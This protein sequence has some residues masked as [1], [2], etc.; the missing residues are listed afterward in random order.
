MLIGPLKALMLPLVMAPSY[1]RQPPGPHP[2]SLKTPRA[3]PP[4][5]H[6][7]RVSLLKV[8]VEGAEL[9]VLQG[10]RDEDWPKI[11]QVT[12]EV[13]APRGADEALLEKAKRGTVG[14]A[15]K[16]ALPPF[17]CAAIP[18]TATSTKCLRPATWRLP[19]PLPPKP[20]PPRDRRPPQGADP[21]DAAR[22]RLRQR[23]VRAVRREDAAGHLA[24][25]RDARPARVMMCRSGAGRPVVL[26]CG[27][28][29]RTFLGSGPLHFI[30][31][32]GCLVC[33]LMA[34]K[35]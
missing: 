10:I 22:A 28:E 18:S 23:R 32:D 31:E 6:R 4:H 35:H 34:M 19:C 7:R 16:V 1:S 29:G 9:K 17:D 12:V 27:D 26:R 25:V 15:S 33:I 2:L 20:D 5:R 30:L 21:R 24:G 13:R 11:E 3:R 14:A 8:D